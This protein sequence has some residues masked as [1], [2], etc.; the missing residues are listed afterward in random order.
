MENPGRDKP[1]KGDS[2]HPEVAK[3][4]KACGK[5][6]EGTAFDAIQRHR[7]APIRRRTSH[8]AELL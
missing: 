5:A 1:F 4:I 8:L 7:Q 3:A 2:Y 6:G